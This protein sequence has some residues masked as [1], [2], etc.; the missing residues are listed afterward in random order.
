MF[1][2]LTAKAQKVIN[3][4]AQEEAKKLNA[5]LIQPEHIFL[6]LIREPE[7]VAVKVLQ[8]LNIDTDKIRYELE[9]AVKKPNATLMLGDLQPSER[10]NKVLALSAEEAKTLNHHYIGTEHLL[11]G[12]YREEEG[13]VYNLLENHQV[14]LGTLRRITVDML[15]FGVL[16]KSPSSEKAKK[17]PTV[18]T[19]G[20]DLT[21]LARENKL[22]PVIGR[23]NEITRLIQILSRRT[24]NNP[25]LIGEPGVGK[26]AIVEGLALRIIEKEIPDL[27]Q[28]KRVVVL[29]MA[30][31]VAGTKYRG[32]FEERLKNIMLEVKRAANIIL[33]IDEVHTLIGAGGAEGAM[34]AA[35]ILKPALARGELQCIGSTTMKEYKRYIEKDTALVRRFQPILVNEPSVTDTRLIL[36]GIAKKYEEFHNVSYDPEALD[37]ASTLSKRY[38][39]DRFLPDTAIDLIDESGARA[40]LRNTNRPKHL[41]DMELEI[42]DLTREKNEVVKTQEFEK[43]AQV[44]D[45]IAAKKEHLEREIEKWNEQRKKEAV[46]IHVDDITEIISSMTGIPLIRLEESESSRLLKMEDALHKR[47][48]GQH[49]AIQALCRAIRRSR[50]GIRSKKRPAGSFIFMGPTGVGKTE[51]A[52]ALAEFLFGT[53]DSIIRVD[54]SEFMEKHSVSRLIGAPPGY[55]GYEEGGELTDKVRRRPYSIIL[56]DEIEKA[57]SDIYNILLQILEE[58][59]LSDNLGHKVDF[60]NTIIIMTSNLG[61]KDIVKGQSLGFG[62]AR[63]LADLGEIKAIALDELKR[64]FNP[65]LLNRIDETIV[66]HPLT[67]EH[68]GSILDILLL[69]VGARLEEQNIHLELSAAVRKHLIGK[70][71]D[72]NYGAR[73]LRRTIQS[74]LEDLLATALLDGRIKAGQKA[75]VDLVD[76]K[77]DVVETVA[78]APP[79]ADAAAATSDSAQL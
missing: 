13:T 38:L 65:E 31:T 21:Q 26:S 76:G 20:R 73:P 60:T 69:E 71:Y 51:L 74:E 77:L 22:D 32:E 52:K 30:A 79:A 43:A 47:V 12:I 5:D 29:D 27:L 70:G 49:E 17:T 16:P 61:G 62:P 64:I 37:A 50:A 78:P 56:L 44:R 42:E 18:D 55:I 45:A 40:R 23:Q 6:G 14:N 36:E 54:M 72:R 7:S 68:V 15:G 46:H 57:H 48:V 19:F 39:T 41:K 67:E 3:Q 66:F 8:K 4:Y 9:N 59:H 24:K 1:S 58:G 10:V 25:I 75:H 33:F 28:G 34:D 2:G 11:L 63:N 35:N 53:E